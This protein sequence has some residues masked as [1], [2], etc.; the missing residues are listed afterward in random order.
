M[1]MMVLFVRSGS[2]GYETNIYLRVCLLDIVFS[3]I[4]QLSDDNMCFTF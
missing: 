2:A 4:S 3:D 1:N